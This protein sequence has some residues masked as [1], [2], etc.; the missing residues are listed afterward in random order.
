[1]KLLIASG[2]DIAAFEQV[3][4]SNKKASHALLIDVAKTFKAKGCHVR[5]IALRGDSREEL[6]FKIE[7]VKADLVIVGSRGLSGFKKAFL[8]SVSDHLMHHLKC[9]VLVTR[10]AEPTEEK[11]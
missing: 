10:F 1:M 8:G 7:E 3:E 11:K 6:V 2:V 4:Q 5:A 9:P